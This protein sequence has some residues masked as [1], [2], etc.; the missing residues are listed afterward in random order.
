MAEDI[1]ALLSLA[2]RVRHTLLEDAQLDEQEEASAA[3]ASAKEDQGEARGTIPAA[4]A[5]SLAPAK[6][7]L[8][9]AAYRKIRA[10]EGLPKLT[11]AELVVMAS[12][13]ARIVKA[14]PPAA[15]AK[16]VARIEGAFPK[17]A[18]Q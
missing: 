18:E 11:Q 6:P 3:V 15:L 1:T 7:E 9:V 17:A 10:A 13:M 12:A 14:L 5:Q 2:S 16:I 8:F 4:T